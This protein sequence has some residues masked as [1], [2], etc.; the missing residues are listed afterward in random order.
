MMRQVTSY[1]TISEEYI[2]STSTD[3]HCYESIYKF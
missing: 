1:S 3:V 2:E